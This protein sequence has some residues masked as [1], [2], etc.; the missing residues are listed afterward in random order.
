MSYSFFAT[1]YSDVSYCNESN[2][3][4]Y[5]FYAK[6]SEGVLKNHG[7]CKGTISDAT[8]G[9]MYAIHEALKQCQVEWP[10]LEGFF[11]NT[12]SQTSCHLLWPDRIKKTDHF[13]L[14][15]AQRIKKYIQ[16][17]CPEKEAPDKP[18]LRVKHVKAHTGNKDVRSYLNRYCDKKAIKKLRELREERNGS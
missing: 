10:H 14:P 11:V 18:W 13:K 1:I 16:E 3:A 4:V 15:Q 6:S 9:E 5:A 2:I 7:E 17:I 12:D 8:A